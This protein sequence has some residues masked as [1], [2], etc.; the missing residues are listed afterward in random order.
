LN[1]KVIIGDCREVLKSLPEKSIHC[2]VTSPPYFGLRSYCAV[3]SNEKAL[4]IGI[5]QTPEEYVFNL[6]EVFREVKRV[7]RDD[8]SAWLNLGDSYSGGGRGGDPKHKKDS[9]S[10]EN[11][12]P[13]YKGIP[14]KNLIGIPWQVAFALQKD[15]WILR[16][17][18]VWSKNNPMPES[19]KD[20]PTKAHEYIFLLAKSQKYYFDNESIKEPANYD[21]R[22]DTM[23]KGS[24]KYKTS[25]VPDKKEHTMA[26]RG[27]ERW[28]YDTNGVPVRNKRSVWNV[29]TKPYKGAHFATFPPALIEPCIK[30]GTSEKGVCSE[31]GSS[32]N[33]VMEKTGQFQR[34]WSKNNAE[35]SP[36]NSQDSMQNTYRTVSWEPSCSCNAPVIPATV[37]DPF[38]GSGTVGEVCNKLGRNYIL[39]ELNPE[40]KTLID[41]RV[42]ISI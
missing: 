27:H 19:C 18:I 13:S 5:E 38:G 32:Y 7:L 37:L 1:N 11:T 29:N 3:G 41:T 12:A 23:M 39:I 28:Q 8:G 22:K 17:D 2:C 9:N 4:E 35:D 10:A 15:G 14:A 31:C 16:S 6:V 25:V 26:A 21:G 33:R 40:Y 34:R 36:Y 30:A 20:R 42:S 24:E